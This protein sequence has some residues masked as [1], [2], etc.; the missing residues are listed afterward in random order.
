MTLSSKQ[1]GLA[2][3]L[4]SLT[5][6]ALYDYHMLDGSGH[7]AVALSGG[8]D[9]LTLL[10][11]LK[12]IV[13]RGFP[14]AAITA[15][16]IDGAYTCGAGVNLR[17][18][19]KL[20]LQLEIPLITRRSE[21]TLETLECYSCSRERRS[22]L[23]DAAKSVGAHVI[24]FGH[25]RDDNAQTVM[26]NLLHKGE[27]AG[28]QPKITMRTYGVTI[29]RPLIYVPEEMVRTYAKQEGFA[30]IS[31]QCPVGQ[32][33]RRKQ[34]DRLLGEMADLFPNA[35]QNLSDAVLNYGSDKALIR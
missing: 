16:H 19:E 29:I 9:S 33:S 14:D 21:Q 23:F 35:K 27:F 22:L 25:H 10:T 12:K 32:N 5:R 31:C 15:I 17:Y 4:E 2:R 6:K 7:L 11:M 20:C 13:G 8:K 28:M 34:V 24:A 30:R 1:T 26:M 18:L 3:R